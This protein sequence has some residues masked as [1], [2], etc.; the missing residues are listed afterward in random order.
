MSNLWEDLK[1]SLRSLSRRP[2][3]T[4]TAILVIAIGAGATTAIFSVVNGVLLKPLDYKESRDLVTVGVD[5]AGRPTDVIDFMSPPDVADLQAESSALMTLVGYTS[6]NVALTGSGEPT[7]VA[8]AIVSDGLLATFRLTPV[9]GRDIRAD[10]TGPGAPRVAVISHALWR[11]RFGMAPEVLGRV[12]EFGGRRFEIVGVAPEGFS[13]PG[14]TQVWVPHRINP[15]SCGRRC[16]TWRTIGRLSPGAT[17]ASAQ[18]QADVIAG[19]LS[20]AYPESNFEKGFVVLSLQDWVVGDARAGLWILLGTVTVLLLIACANVSNLLLIRASDRTGEIAVRTAL[21]ASRRRVAMQVTVEGA[22]LTVAGGA[23]GLLMAA[24][25]VEVFRLTSAGIVPRAAEVSVDG[26]VL[27]FTLG[28]IVAVTLLFAVIPAVFLIRVPLS[29][30]LAHAG[31]RSGTGPIGNRF[32]R[33]LVGIEVALSVTLL[34]GAGLLLRSFGQLYA[35]ELGFETRD[36]VRF[37]VTLPSDIRTFYRTLEEQVAAVP[38]VES[39]GSIYGAPLGVGHTTSVVLVDGRPEPEPGH[40]TYSAIRGVTPG[41]LE[42]ARI[43]VIRGRAIGP[44]DD[45]GSVPVG[46][47]NQAFARENFPG[48]EPLGKRVRIKTDMGYGSPYWTIVGIV[49]DIRSEALAQAP[50]PEIYVP[51]ARFGGGLMTV[52]VRTAPGFGAALPEIRSAVYSAYPDL[53]LRGVETVSEAVQREVAPTRFYLLLLGFIAILAL[54]LAAVGLYGVLQYLVSRRTREFGV[55]IALGAA[56][57]E[58]ARM[59]TFEMLRPA[60]LGVL[61]GLAVSLWAGRMLEAFLYRVSPRDLWTF[62]AVPVVLLLVALLAVLL[63]ARRA[64]RTE[65][66]EALRLD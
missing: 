55:R 34:I 33:T 40:E 58:L 17:V 45:I 5:P 22:V 32:R 50:V 59:V 24:W 10:E 47:I 26:T 21:G 13:Y 20:E 53:P 60:S 63:P 54:T 28:L 9:Q 41:Y 31:R 6:R 29:A 46:V 4:I 30:S 39:V 3:F 64:S 11:E 37:T 2:G 42:T 7:L 35:V 48:E 16:H 15:E 52:T 49:G 57:G 23:L 62:A 38:G 51:I 65:P 8:V 66:I 25:G 14:R 44:A 56:P 19:R 12:I 36:I 1:F 61:S 18:G 43:P 27:G